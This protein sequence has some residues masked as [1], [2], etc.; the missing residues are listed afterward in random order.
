MMKTNVKRILLSLC[1]AVAV[2]GL[3]FLLLLLYEL[4]VRYVWEAVFWIYFAV[5]AAA[6][7]FV[8]V[9]NRGFSRRFMRRADLPSAW[10]EAQKDQ[11]MAEAAAW[12]RVSKPVLLYVILPLCLCF[13]F[14]ILCLFLWGPLVELFPILS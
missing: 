7:L 1:K 5:L 4:S 6:S 14:D 8:A 9:Y 2:L 3:T 10:S 12:W 11:F 13:A